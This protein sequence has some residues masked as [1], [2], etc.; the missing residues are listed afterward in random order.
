MTRGLRGASGTGGSHDGSGCGGSRVAR[1]GDMGAAG[2]SVDDN[3][4]Q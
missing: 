1:L 4:W 3:Q 2:R